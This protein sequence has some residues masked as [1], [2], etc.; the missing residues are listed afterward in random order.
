MHISRGCQQHEV[1]LE[2]R[3]IWVLRLYRFASIVPEV[4]AITRKEKQPNCGLHKSKK[5]ITKLT[6]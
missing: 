3:K 4:G 6:S 1:G 5:Q 2:H